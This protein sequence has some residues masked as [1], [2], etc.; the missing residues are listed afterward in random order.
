MTLVSI[1]NRHD[2]DVQVYLE[3]VITHLNRGT[4]KPEQLLPDVWK[5]SA[6]QSEEGIEDREGSNSRR[7]AS[8][9]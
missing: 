3:D 6:K 2:L 5:A 1:A 7:V 4:A 8:T 9:T